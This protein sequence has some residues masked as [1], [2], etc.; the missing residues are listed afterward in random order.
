MGQ[1]GA[2]CRF[3]GVAR[4][5]VVIRVSCRRKDALTRFLNRGAHLSLVFV[6]GC[7]LVHQCEAAE[8]YRCM[9]GVVVVVAS[10]DTASDERGDGEQDGCVDGVVQVLGVLVDELVLAA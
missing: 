5:T 8:A 10:F 1:A 7:L 6:G 9:L 2:V 4:S 3:A